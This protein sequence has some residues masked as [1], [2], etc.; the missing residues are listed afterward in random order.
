MRFRDYWV[1]VGFI[2]AALTAGAVGG[3]VTAAGLGDWYLGLT[4]PK[5]NPPQWVF[6]PVWTALYLLMAL[7]VWRVW[8]VRSRVPAARAVVG[9]YFVQLVL[10]AG[11]TVLFF[12]LRMPGWALVDLVVLLLLLAWLQVYL[13]EVDQLAGALW[14]PYVVW[15]SFAGAL[16]AAIWRMNP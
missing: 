6:G 2:L 11:W 8:L 10:N 13:W 9:M 1:L 14:V 5:W 16:N 15:V 12:G 3:V 7:A 4:K